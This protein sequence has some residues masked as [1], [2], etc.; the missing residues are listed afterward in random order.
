LKKLIVNYA[1]REKRYAL[2]INNQ[3]EKIV[4]D[5]PEHQSLV[6][7]IYYGTVTKVLPGMNA[8]FV[9]IGEEKNAYLHRDLLAKYVLSNEDNQVKEAK[10]ITKFVHQGERIIVQVNKD[11]TG[12]K[13]PRV[14]GINEIQGNYLIYMPNGRY[15]AVSKKIVEED[16]KTSL[17]HLG[18]RIKGEMEGIIFRTSSNNVSEEEISEEFFQLRQQYEEM[19]RKADSLK[20]PDLLF[21]KETFVEIL[22]ETMERMTNG[23]VILDDLGLKQKLESHELVKKGNVKLTYFSQKE[24]LFSSLRVEHEIEKAL[25]RV[26][27]L[28][29]GSYLIFDEAEALTIIDVNTGK[30]SGKID[31]HDTV[32]KTNH[33]AS[34]EIAR[35]LRLRDIGGMVLIDFIDMKRDQDRVSILETMEKELK[36]DEKRTKVFGFTPLG[37]LQL[38]RKKT[39]VTLSEALQVRCPECAGTGRVDSVETVAFRLERELFEHRHSEFEAVLVETTK[40]VKEAFEG[41]NQIY[42]N[43]FEQATHLKVFFSIT[44]KNIPYY[45]LKQFGDESAIS[46][47]RNGFY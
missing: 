9:D 25:K 33:L 11:A 45:H 23:E 14:T 44:P 34:I 3:V 24:N 26:V 38:T 36:R 37:I 40:E 17:R 6:G 22:T 27:W 2:M 20:K 42:R 31:L 12:T 39:R 18:T 47:K 29:N 32:L 41:P 10:S 30:F 28:E 1:S 8:V 15:V 46:S 4:I 16:K 35:Q 19:I 21:Q 13:G 5:R 43:H 7:N